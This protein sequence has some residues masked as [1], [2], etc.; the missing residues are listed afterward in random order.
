MLGCPGHEAFHV[1]IASFHKHAMEFKNRPEF[2][3]IDVFPNG[4]FELLWHVLS[5]FAAQWLI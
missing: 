1:V 2:G 4:E 3:N 5:V